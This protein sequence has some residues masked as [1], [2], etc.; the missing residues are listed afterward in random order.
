VEGVGEVGQSEEVRSSG[1]IYVELGGAVSAQVCLF[2][3]P[4]SAAAAAVALLLGGGEPDGLPATTCHTPVTPQLQ[5]WRGNGP[6][7]G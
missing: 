1:T 5:P 4:C 6:R 2:S 7:E 3:S